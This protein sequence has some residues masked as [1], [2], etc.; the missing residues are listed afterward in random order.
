MVVNLPWKCFCRNIEHSPELLV[1]YVRNPDDVDEDYTPSDGET[2]NAALDLAD[3]PEFLIFYDLGL[4][5]HPKAAPER[6]E[7][8]FL[9]DG[10]K[11]HNWVMDFVNNV[12]HAEHSGVGHSTGLFSRMVRLDG[13]ENNYRLVKDF[14]L[15]YREG[16]EEEF[17]EGRRVPASWGGLAEEERQH[18]QMVHCLTGLEKR[19][20]AS[21][22]F[23]DLDSEFM[24]YLKKQPSSRFPPS[25][26]VTGYRKQAINHS[27]RFFPALGTNGAVGST[28]SGKIQ[29]EAGYDHQGFLQ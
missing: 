18:R 26:G 9:T 15:E 11:M 20:P 1:D 17:Q 7:V 28:H 24:D 22:V 3:D 27:G 12:R 21:V 2:A 10:I 25:I 4:Q 6:E 5:F 29:L 13:K 8:C 16:L 19:L 23:G 14:L